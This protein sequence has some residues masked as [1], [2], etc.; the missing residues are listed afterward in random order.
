MSL[1]FRQR[2]EESVRQRKHPLQRQAAPLGATAPA[3]MPCRVSRDTLNRF[4]TAGPH[5]LY[6]PW[7]FNDSDRKRG[8]IMGKA[9]RLDPPVKTG[10]RG[11]V[12][13]L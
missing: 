13:M 4:Q 1:L 6:V 9:V 5:A 8:V 2:V 10:A 3:K 12:R 7:N 11:R